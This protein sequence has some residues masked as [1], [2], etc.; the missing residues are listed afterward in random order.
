[1]PSMLSPLELPVIFHVLSYWRPPRGQK[2]QHS[3][4]PVHIL[5]S[6]GRSSS[7]IPMESVGHAATHTPHWTH[8]SA[9]MTDF[10]RSQNQTFPGAS[11]M[12]FIKS[13]MSKPATSHAPCSRHG[14]VA[15]PEAL[16]WAC[17][18]S[19]RGTARPRG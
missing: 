9:S 17:A 11:S 14:Y 8:L 1:M 13:R 19:T 2:S 15:S 6:F 3:E 10:S 18:G 16:C 12:S 4:Q 7:P 5:T